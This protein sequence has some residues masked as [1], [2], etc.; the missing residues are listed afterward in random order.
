MNALN[1]AS[2]AMRYAGI[3]DRALFDMI[4]NL[5]ILVTHALMLLAAWRLLSRDDLDSE[6]TVDTSIKRT[7]PL[8]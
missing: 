8:A 7:R 3:H 6:R 4:D 1:D 2:T 5:A